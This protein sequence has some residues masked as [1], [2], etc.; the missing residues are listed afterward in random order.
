M[1]HRRESAGLGLLPKDTDVAPAPTHFNSKKAGKEAPVVGTLHHLF[2]GS[3]HQNWAA[4][5]AMC[6]LFLIIGEEPPNF[7][8]FVD[9]SANCDSVQLLCKCGTVVQPR[10]SILPDVKISQPKV[11]LEKVRSTNKK[12]TKKKISKKRKRKRGSD[13]S[14]ESAQMTPDEPSDEHEWCGHEEDERRSPKE[15]MLEALS[16]WKCVLDALVHSQAKQVHDK[17]DGIIIPVH[18]STSTSNSTG[19][20]NSNGPPGTRISQSPS[21]V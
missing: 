4:F 16:C 9:W 8:R 5:Q 14:E 11:P 21:H 18:Y 1:L 6:E 10:K 19:N 12:E 17:L 15:I 2:P 13:S 20:A 3:Y 7:L